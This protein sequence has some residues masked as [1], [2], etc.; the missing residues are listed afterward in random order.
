MRRSEYPEKLEIVQFVMTMLGDTTPSIE[1]MGILK[2]VTL[3]YWEVRRC[4]EITYQHGR[5]S[6]GVGVRPGHAIR[7]GTSVGHQMIDELIDR[8]V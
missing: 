4:S 7:S 8:P 6:A 5:R 2:C 1:V 3:S